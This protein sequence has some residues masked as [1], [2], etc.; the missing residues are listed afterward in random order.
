ME[1][2]ATNYETFLPLAESYLSR[3][4]VTPTMAKTHR[5]GVVGSEEHGHEKDKGR[6]SIPYIDRLG[7]YGFKFRCIASHDCKEAG[8]PKYTN[9]AGQE[10]SLYNVL[11]L[12]SDSETLHITEGELDAVVLSSFIAGPVVAIPGAQLWKKHFPFHLAGFARVLVWA[13]GD[14]AGSKM[15]KRIAENCPQAEILSMPP[16]EDVNSMF[17]KKGA[18]FFLNKLLVEV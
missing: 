10:L 7:V 2:A 11:A 9:P 17:L 4:G 14:D 3:R 15:A 12:D 8:C 5:L 6:L 18:E 1:A 13:D 16:G